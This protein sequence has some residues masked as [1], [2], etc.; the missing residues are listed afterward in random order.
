[1]IDVEIDF[2][3]RLGKA[4]D[5]G[6]RPTCLVFAGSDLN[7]AANDVGHL[8]AE[9]LCHHAAQLAHEWKP[10]RGFQMDEVLGA[11]ASPGQ[12]LEDRYPY[13]PYVRETP[14]TVPK[15]DFELYS[16]KSM[17]SPDVH[18]DELVMRAL[19][20]QAVGIV[21]RMTR[22]VWSPK[23][24]VI[25]FDS[26]VIPDQYHALIVVGVGRQLVTGERYLLLRNSWGTYWGTEGHAWMSATHLNLLLLESFLI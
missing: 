2:A 25:D 4:R 7:A 6:Q 3:T 20:G 16:S 12:P 18:C 22:S 26:L 19:S 11:V 15:G 1:M 9:F 8:S 13:Q 23:A 5:Q 14:L 21:I 17:R 24:G 10:E